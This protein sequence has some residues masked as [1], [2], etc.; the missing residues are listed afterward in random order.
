MLARSPGCFH[1]RSASALC[2]S[3]GPLQADNSTSSLSKHSIGTGQLAAGIPGFAEVTPSLY[4]G[5]QP[6]LTSMKTLK[7]MGVDIVVNMRGGRNRYE[8]AEV[9]KLGMQ[10]FSI[11]WH[12]PFPPDKP[13]ARFLKLIEDKPGKKVFV[14]CRLGDDRTGMAVA[15]YR[16]AEQGWS[17]EE[18]MNEMKAFGFTRTHHWICPA[19]A[20]YERGFPKRLKTSRPSKTCNCTPPQTR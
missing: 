19:L 17:A 15:A 4:R 18:A 2:I 16:M 8:E 14:H 9:R 20:S 5:G 11:P 7:K 1:P 12:C 3:A 6:D 10:Y 13:F